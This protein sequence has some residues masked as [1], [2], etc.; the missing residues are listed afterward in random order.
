MIENQQVAPSSSSKIVTRYLVICILCSV[1]G[2]YICENK[3][4]N[5]EPKKKPL[6][7]LSPDHFIDPNKHDGRQ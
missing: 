2:L 4:T 7:N 6:D 3:T 1:F 5:Y